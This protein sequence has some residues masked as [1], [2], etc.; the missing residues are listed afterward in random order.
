MGEKKK[1]LPSDPLQLQLPIVVTRGA[2]RQEKRAKF[3]PEERPAD[4]QAEDERG[5][6]ES[7]LL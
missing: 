5:Y 7:E 6:D 3:E 4:E 2:R 1:V